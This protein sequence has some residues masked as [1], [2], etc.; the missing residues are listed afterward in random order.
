MISFGQGGPH[1]RPVAPPGQVHRPATHGSFV[2]H[3]GTVGVERELRDTYGRLG[4][5]G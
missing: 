2:V 3:S 5:D 1:K 4:A